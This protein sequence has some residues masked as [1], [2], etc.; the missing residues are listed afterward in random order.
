MAMAG[1]KADEIR[2]VNTLCKVTQDQQEAASKLA[3]H[4]QLV[5][6]IGGTNSANTRH[7]VEICSLLTETHSIETAEEVDITWLA[8]KRRIGI[9]AGAST[10]D[11]SVE[12]LI[13]KLRSLVSE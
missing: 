1:P 2:L 3:R 6:V 11:Q 12:E 10:P 8:G 9:T 7:L 13:D 5:I 4:S